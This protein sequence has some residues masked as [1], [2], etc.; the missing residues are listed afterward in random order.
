[1]QCWE[2]DVAVLN[3]TGMVKLLSLFIHYRQKIN[4][5]TLVVLLHFLFLDEITIFKAEQTIN[6]Q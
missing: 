1:M 4:H 6:K 5:F 3:T 2:M